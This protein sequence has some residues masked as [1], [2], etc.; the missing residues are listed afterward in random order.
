MA[1]TIGQIGPV[2]Y[3]SERMK[4]D[5]RNSTVWPA[6]IPRQSAAV[7]GVNCDQVHDRASIRISLS[8]DKCFR[9]VSGG[10]AARRPTVPWRSWCRC[11]PVAPPRPVRCTRHARTAQAGRVRAGGHRGTVPRTPAGRGFQWGERCP[12][13]SATGCAGS[14]DRSPHHRCLLARLLACPRTIRVRPL[15][16]N[17]RL[18]CLRCA[19]PS[20]WR[21][22]SPWPV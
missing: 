18:G 22:S 1:R 9:R 13:G 16:E 20:G 10:A 17:A 4:N 5:R 2:V 12:A 21:S 19:S 6:G 15:L 11:P 8:F 3:S 7:M 14:A